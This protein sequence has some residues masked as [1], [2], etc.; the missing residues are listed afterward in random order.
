[1]IALLP[2]ARPGAASSYTL[3]PSS[4]LALKPSSLTFPEAAALPLSALTAYQA[5]FTHADAQPGQKL[6]VAGAGGGVGA[7]V[8]QM[9]VAA[10]M[11][12]TGVCSAGK[13]DLV[14]GLG[15]HSVIDREQTTLSS[16]S[17]DYDVVIDT[18][19]ST[20][21]PQLFPLLKG[22]GQLI[23]IARPA[24]EDEK[25]QRPDVR[26]MFFIVEPDGE[27]LTRI[28]QCVEQEVLRPMV[29]KVM[30][31]EAGAEAFDVV[32]KGGVGG[33]VVLEVEGRVDSPRL[34]M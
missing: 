25:A 33:K 30:P 7:I 28:V 11:V 6:L 21:L 17:H 14:R 1:M 2:F 16:L 27:E 3:A 31:L 22:K 15:A 13:A 26:A 29:G 34:T 4:D 19:G 23:C 24:T 8:V 9:A 18:I 10:R 5:L 20:T 32:G 12:V